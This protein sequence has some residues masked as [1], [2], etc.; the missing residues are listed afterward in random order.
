MKILLTLISAMMMFAC[1]PI[2][3][4]MKMDTQRDTVIVEKI[5]HDTVK[6]NTPISSMHGK[7]A[8]ELDM[9]LGIKKCN[10][11]SSGIEYCIVD[12]SKQITL[13]DTTYTYLCEYKQGWKCNKMGTSND[14]LGIRPLL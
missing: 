8:K 10:T 4:T 14:P 9:A 11:T 3:V 5:V 12:E 6:I 7:G 2:E 1:K 13:N